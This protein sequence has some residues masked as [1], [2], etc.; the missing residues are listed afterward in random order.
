MHA[1]QGERERATVE[2]FLP[3]HI[4]TVSDIDAIDTVH[5]NRNANSDANTD[6]VA[7]T[8]HTYHS[9]SLTLTTRCPHR[10]PSCSLSSLSTQK[11]AQ[12]GGG[13]IAQSVPHSAS[14][15]PPV[16][17][18]QGS[19]TTPAITCGIRISLWPP[20]LPPPRPHATPL[21]GGTGSQW[22]SLSSSPRWGGQISRG[23]LDRGMLMRERTEK[24]RE[25][26]RRRKKEQRRREKTRE[27]KR[28][29]IMVV[30]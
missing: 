6:A 13:S 2:L 16:T 15:S 9:H 3:S 25:A 17:S 27:A 21:R 1:S 19:G 20:P 5:S 8:D 10:V 26:K 14:A 4:T 24:K 7:S 18:R 11:R 23:F 28:R 29:Y 12:R 22:S 30:E